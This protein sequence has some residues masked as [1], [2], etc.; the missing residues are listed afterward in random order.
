MKKLSIFLVAAFVIALL[1][2]PVAAQTG[3]IKGFVKDENGKPMVGVVVQLVS[4]ETGRKYEL[5][6]DKNGNLF[7]LGIAS[8]QYDVRLMKDG[9]QIWNLNGWVAKLDENKL[10][11]DM[12]KEKA[13]QVNQMSEAEKARIEAINKENSKIK[14]LNDLLSQSKAAMDSGNPQQA[15]D[16]LTQAT[17]LDPS[18]YILWMNL[19]D[20]QRAAALKQTDPAAKKAGLQGSIESY[21]KAI[22]L[23]GTTKPEVVGAAYNNLAQSYVSLGQTEDAIKAYDQA[24]ASDPTRAGNYY[25]NEGAVFTNTGKVDEAIKAFDKTIQADPTKAVAYYWKGV[26]LMGKATLK[27]NKMEAPEGTSEAFNKYL[28]LDPTGQFA[29]PAKDMLASIGADVQT[30]FGKPKAAAKKK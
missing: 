11:I 25:F 7:S 28:E 21:N 1:A 3:S 23:A 19:A 18:R 8:G 14:G 22:P 29:Q 17:Q 5:K 16:L 2:I 9:V 30:S 6:P 10:E 27:G 4:K 26:N 20:A 13:M 15:V 24:V 12:A